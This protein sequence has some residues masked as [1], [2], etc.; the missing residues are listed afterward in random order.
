MNEIPLEYWNKLANQLIVVSSLMSGFSIAVSANLL[1]YKSNSRVISNILKAST[2][3]AA[4]FLV[5][6]FSM[7]KI[8]MMTTPGFPLN[9]VISDLTFPKL[10]GILTF[11]LGIFSLAT[12]IALAGWVKSRRIGIFTTIVSIVMLLLVLF[13]LVDIQ[14]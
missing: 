12:V 4:A 1:V 11:I 9:T 13:T 6:V 10:I 5:T 14:I 7:T 3:A 2:V 8:L